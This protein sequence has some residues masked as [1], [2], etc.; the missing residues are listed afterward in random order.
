MGIVG[1]DLYRYRQYRTF[2]LLCRILR[3]VP[4][5][6]FG[7]HGLPSETLFALAFCAYCCLIYSFGK[8][9]QVIPMRCPC[10]IYMNYDI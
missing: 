5:N 10:F 4:V 6:H 9:D 1:L 8:P 2:P 7:W 3:L